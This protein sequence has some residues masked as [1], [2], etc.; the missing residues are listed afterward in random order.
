LG[1][2]WQRNA[3]Q[4]D[5]G[6]G[7]LRCLAAG[8][9]AAS[10]AGCASV[11]RIE[12]SRASSARIQKVTLVTV[13]QMPSPTVPDDFAYIHGGMGLLGRLHQANESNSA[14]YA[15]AVRERTA[16]LAPG[17]EAALAAALADAGYQ[18][19]VRGE[20]SVVRTDDDTVDVFPRHGRG[21]DPDGLGIA[22]GLHPSRRAGK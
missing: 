19:D 9:L 1:N 6:R 22:A 21:C 18:V 4:A 12:L 3:N 13:A 7:R 14:K 11:P 10:I 16:A 20:E 2:A 15:D 17:M 8:L 5:V